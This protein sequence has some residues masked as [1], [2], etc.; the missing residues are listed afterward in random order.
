MLAVVSLVCSV[1]VGVVAT[2]VSGDV[3]VGHRVVWSDPMGVDLG[4]GVDCHV[5]V[6]ADG[7]FERLCG[8]LRSLRLE[9]V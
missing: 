3:V 8:G 2:P 1:L 7:E 5:E 9:V 6:H 4:D